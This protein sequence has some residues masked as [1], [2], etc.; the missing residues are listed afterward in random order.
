MEPINQQ[1]TQ[2]PKTVLVVEDDEM[3]LELVAGVLEDNGYRVLKAEDGVR[4]V[5]QYTLHHTR[6]AVVLTDMGLPRLGGWEA[7]LKMKEVNPNV[8]T[9]MASGYF[10]PN[11]RAEMVNA[12]AV[13]FVQKPYVM[14]EVLQKIHDVID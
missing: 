12:G 5:E 3:L 9:I 4:A 14:N 2:N 10:D 13:D 7:F 6:V 11:L 8:K 1:Q